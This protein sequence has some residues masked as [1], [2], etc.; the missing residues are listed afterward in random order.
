MSHINWPPVSLS[1]MTWKVKLPSQKG[2]SARVIGT[3]TAHVCPGGTRT[4]VR[5]WRW[6]GCAWS[7]ILKPGGKS[8]PFN[9]RAPDSPS[10]CG[11]VL[12]SGPYKGREVYREDPRP[13]A[14]PH[15]SLCVPQGPAV[16]ED[17]RPTTSQGY[18]NKPQILLVIKK[19]LDA[20]KRSDAMG[21][22]Q[23]H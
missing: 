16:R 6:S 23:P 18:E 9:Q 19:I 8:L 3:V 12:L 7:H 5:A 15:Q 10:G 11:T 2:K 21:L 4:E 1:R 20:K 13:P 22:L 17:R 14:W